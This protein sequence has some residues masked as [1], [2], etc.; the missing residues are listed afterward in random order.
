MG[1]KGGSKDMN[2]ARNRLKKV[3]TA[4]EIC[5]D[6]RAQMKD[7]AWKKPLSRASSDPRWF[8]W[9]LDPKRNS[10]CEMKMAPTADRKR[11]M[12]CK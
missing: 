8:S 11:A 3:K 7:A 2:T 12:K 5:C 6:F 1:S 10:G 9:P 4:T